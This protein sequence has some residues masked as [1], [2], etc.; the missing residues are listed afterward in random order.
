[1]RILK[2]WTS[3]QIRMDDRGIPWSK[4]DFETLNEPWGLIFS[5]CS[6]FAK[7]VP[8]REALAEGWLAYTQ[9]ALLA[10]STQQQNLRQSMWYYLRGETPLTWPQDHPFDPDGELERYVGT[11][12]QREQVLVHFIVGEMLASL[13]YT[14]V[15]KEG[16]LFKISW[17]RIED[18]Q[19]AY[20]FQCSQVKQEWVHLLQDTDRVVTFAIATNNC[21]VEE[22]Q[23]WQPCK[24]H[25][26][27]I[28]TLEALVLLDT[29]VIPAR[30]TSA[31]W[32]FSGE[33]CYLIA[34]GPRNSRAP[35][36]TTRIVCKVQ[37]K[38]SVRELIVL[39]HGDLW[40]RVC[41]HLGWSSQRVREADRRLHPDYDGS[42]P[43]FVTDFENWRDARLV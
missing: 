8:L 34:D 16:N 29:R 6:N 43:V 35:S 30:G 32:R 21:L 12:N 41:V 39:G 10:S 7:R 17:P 38:S 11:L 14:G 26:K 4:A 28:A 20:H 18:S 33:V 3:S 1:M 22:K 31:G 13:Q 15:V 42:E 25:G 19:V 5:I 9:Q 24:N 40:E 23:S 36:T 2:D 27:T 37:H